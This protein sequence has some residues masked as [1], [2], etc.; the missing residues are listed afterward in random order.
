[1]GYL[2][3]FGAIYLPI[4]KKTNEIVKGFSNQ[5]DGQDKTQRTPTIIFVQYHKGVD[6]LPVCN[7]CSYL[8]RRNELTAC[9]KQE[10]QVQEKLK[11][12]KKNLK[13]G[14]KRV[15]CPTTPYQWNECEDIVLLIA[16][17]VTWKC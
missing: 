8:N 2:L 1:M 5:S 3:I 16:N 13:E 17:D 12:L 4:S 10:I 11:L 7:W 9:H 6:V 15:G 14:V